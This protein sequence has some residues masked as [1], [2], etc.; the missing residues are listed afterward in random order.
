MNFNCC[1][2]EFHFE[3]EFVYEF[4]YEYEYE[5]EFALGCIQNIKRSLGPNT[6]GPYM[7]H[8]PNL[9]GLGLVK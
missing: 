3:Y 8:D 6:N 9:V 1:K 2:D 5:F 7:G 4:E